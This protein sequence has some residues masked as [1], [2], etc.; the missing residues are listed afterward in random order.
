MGITKSCLLLLFSFI[1]CLVLGQSGWVNVSVQTDQ[2]AGETSWKIFSSISGEII[3]T[4]DPFTS[5]SLTETVV[6]LSVGSYLFAMYDSYGDGICCNFGEGWFSLTNTCGLDEYVG[7]FDSPLLTIPFVVD[8]CEIPIYGCMDELALNYNPWAMY[9]DVCDTPPVACPEGQTNIIALLAA[10]TYFEEISWDISVYGTEEV[11]NWGGNYTGA[12]Y[13][14]MSSVCATEGDS[15]VATIYDT[16]GDGMCGSC[17]GGVDGFFVVLSLCDHGFF[18]VG[19]ETQYDTLSSPAFVVPHCDPPVSTGCTDEGYLEYNSFAI[20]DDGSCLTPVVLGCTDTEAFNYD[21]NCNTMALEDS[22]DYTLTLIDGG[23]DGWFGSW[24][25]VAQGDSLYGPYEMQPI[26]GNQIDIPLQLNSN[27]EVSVYFF[28]GGNA[29]STAGQ[30]GFSLSGPQGV[31]LDGGTNP[32]TDALLKFPYRYVATPTCDNFCEPYVYGCMDTDAQNYD[33]A[34]NSEDGSCYYN[35]GCMQAG[36]LEYYEQGYVADFDDGSCET[37]AMFG[38]TDPDALN[39]DAEANVDIDSCIEVLVGCVDVNAFN[40]DEEANTADNSLCL[41]DA[42]CVGEPG[43]PYW[44]NDVCYS[45]VIEVDPNCCGSEWDDICGE[46]YSYCQEGMPADIPYYMGRVQ[47]YPNPVENTLTIRC[48]YKVI[49]AV[50]NNFGQRVVSSTTEKVLDL[51]GLSKG[52]YQV[53]VEYN[54]IS[55]NKKIMKL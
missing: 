34:V 38:C 28:T 48:P 8:P 12:Q 17:W 36:Y 15:L 50:Y 19:G 53:I 23:W 14:N 6:T 45:W 39:Y 10:D 41:Y 20:E 33:P 42:G 27:E 40:Y 43:D 3:E 51:S 18:Y 7:D 22:C 21:E 16:Y 30:C 29:E 13:T 4:S 2:Y 52:L 26:D 5:N 55:I 47:I 44:A 37:V 11:L 32:W 1:P 24:L 25:G 54:G 49:T 9:P 31:L 46:I 35:A